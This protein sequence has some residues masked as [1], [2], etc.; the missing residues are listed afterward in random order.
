MARVRI[1]WLPHGVTRDLKDQIKHDA[2]ETGY[3]MSCTVPARLV[4]KAS[5]TQFPNKRH[6]PATI[7]HKT[8]C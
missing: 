3:P 5:P 1:Y 2:S 7:S 6:D 8:R 4:T